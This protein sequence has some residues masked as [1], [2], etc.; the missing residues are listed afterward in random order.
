MYYYRFAVKLDKCVGSCNTFNDLSNKVCVPNKTENLNL[1]MSNMITVM[2][3]SKILT[4]HVSCA[5]KC[6]FH[7]RNVI[8]IK[9][10][11]TTNVD[12]RLKSIIY[13]KKMIQSNLWIADTYDS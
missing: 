10:A 6:K 9:S 4:K 13:V 1:S 3:E 7:A 2:N 12:A 5:C 8:Q 11:V